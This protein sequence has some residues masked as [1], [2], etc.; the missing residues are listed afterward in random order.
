MPGGR[1]H[2][3]ELSGDVAYSNNTFHFKQTKIAANV[4]DAD[5][6]LDIDRQQISG[7]IIARLSLE[8]GMRP[9]GLQIGGVIDRP[10]LRVIP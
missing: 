9:V 10:T 8:E 6:T 1:T 2:Y 5:A 3:D 7:S 4:L